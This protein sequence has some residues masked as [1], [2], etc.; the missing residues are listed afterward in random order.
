MSSSDLLVLA[1]DAR[2]GGGA[3]AQL[4]A[5]LEAAR[6][7]GRRPVTT[8]AGYLPGLDA[9]N[10]LRGGHRLRG[11]AAG[12][13][14]LWVVA[15]TASYGVAA[16]RSGRP[17]ACWLATSFADEWPARIPHLPR[18]RAAA[19]ALNAPLLLR[20]ERTVLERAARLYGT[21]PSS[22][23]AI[24]AAAGLRDD[25]V[26]ILP[27][28]VDPERYS[29]EPD[30]AWVR[31][32]QRPTVVFVG[33]ADDPR[34]NAGLLLEAWP[35]LHREQ[36]DA[37]LVLVGTPPATPVSRG[38]EVRGEV[39]DVAAELRPAAL[40]VLP[41][42]QEGFGIVAAEALACGV[43]VLTTPSGGPEHL[44]RTS[45]GGEVLGGFD[46]TELAT[47]A[48]ALLRDPDRLLRMRHNGRDHIL[49]E[50]SPQRLLTLLAPALAELDP[51]G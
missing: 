50:H 28:P 31:R 16:A 13:R 34:K 51:D 10:Q 30:D 49:R 46:A 23:A 4:D 48:A 14:S 17:Y 35:L 43:P 47:A 33:R 27:L 25:E 3:Q 18:A 15:P 44:V 32:L 5:F 20:L 40:L 37:R 7:L 9:L 22:R 2:F 19:H 41:S 24:A 21:S 45:G 29:P 38:V 36:P 1:Q 26:A 12:A 11:A 39:A 42:W 6:A 8:S